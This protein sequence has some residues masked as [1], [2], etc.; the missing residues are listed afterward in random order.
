MQ[1]PLEKVAVGRSSPSAIGAELSIGPP[2]EF[3]D[4]KEDKYSAVVRME[5]RWRWEIDVRLPAKMADL[6]I[7]EELGTRDKAPGCFFPIRGWRLWPRR[8]A[9]IRAIAD[10]AVEYSG[11]IEGK[12]LDSFILSAACRQA[13]ATY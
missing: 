10:I 8:R 1:G 11:Y 3:H 12:P 5:S 6:E 9:P 4:L 7:L 13:A 2:R